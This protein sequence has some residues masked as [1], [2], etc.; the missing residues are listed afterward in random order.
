MLWDA[1][2]KSTTLSLDIL[3]II[4]GALS[5]S[6]FLK[7][8]GRTK[9]IQEIFAKLITEPRVQAIWITFILG[10]FIEGIAGFGTPAAITEPLLVSLGFSAESAVLSSLTANSVGV[11]FGAL[12]TPILRYKQFERSKITLHLDLADQSPLFFI[13]IFDQMILENPIQ[14]SSFVHSG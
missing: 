4:A 5:F 9:E 11:L 13:D 1:I 6:E 7:E 14:L 8:T 10:S 3:L 12:G 2:L